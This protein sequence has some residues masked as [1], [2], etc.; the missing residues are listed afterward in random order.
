MKTKALFIPVCFAS[1]LATTACEEP[2]EDAGLES[3]SL[4]DSTDTSGKAD[5]LQGRIVQP[6]LT[7]IVEYGADT[8][9]GVTEVTDL[10]DEKMEV[11]AP[12][13]TL[14]DFEDSLQVTVSGDEGIDVRFFLAYQPADD[15]GWYIVTVQ[16]NGTFEDGDE[17]AEGDAQP[18]PVTISYFQSISIL[19]AE[20]SIS[21]ASDGSGGQT[22]TDLGFD[23][24]DVRYA[25]LAL[26]V[27]SGAGNSLE[28]EFKY[29]FDAQ[30][31]GTEC[32]ETPAEPDVPVDDYAQARD[33]TLEAVTIGGDA[34]SY[35]YP[36]VDSGFNLAGTEFWQKWDG[37]HNP[38]YSYTEGTEAGRK[39]MLAS[40]I[41]FEAIM[42]D[43]PPS[44]VELRDNTNWSGRFFNWNDDFS[45]STR[46][47]QGAVLWAWRTGLIKWISQ[48]DRDG[49]CYLPTLE[50]VERAAAACF[51]RGGDD[52]EIQ[53]CQG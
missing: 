47:A 23:G 50:I 39:C 38:T 37:G 32:G 16:G 2:I 27:D 42:A 43:P 41:R 8:K 34:L 51:A 10:S 25:V 4:N 33:V 28:G 21:V 52:G 22:T 24:R 31:D 17:P 18:T 6:Y 14:H 36:S 1:L 9:E 53:G 15:E 35:E 26:P 11:Q 46:S 49:T 5:A 20:N 7:E 13:V 3:V 30:C 19:R 45:Q 12:L 40:A 48:T 44:M 29:T